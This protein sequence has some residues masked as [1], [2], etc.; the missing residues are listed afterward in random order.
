MQAH[1]HCSPSQTVFNVS[2]VID[3]LVVDVLEEPLLDVEFKRRL[4]KVLEDD[5]DQSV[6]RWCARTHPSSSFTMTSSD[7]SWLPSRRNI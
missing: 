1:A 3:K 5:D 7:P 6:V 2:S 4:L